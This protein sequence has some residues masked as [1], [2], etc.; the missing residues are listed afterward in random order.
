MV[1]ILCV[2]VLTGNLAKPGAGFFFLNWDLPLRHIDDDYLAAP[3]LASKKVAQVSHMDLAENLEDTE[4]SKALFTWNINIAASNPEQTRLKNGLLREDLFTVALDLFSTDTTDYADFILPAASFL[5]FDDL[6]AGYFHLTLSAQVK[7][8]EPIGQALPNQEIFR[9]LAR[10]MGYLE[11]ELYENDEVILD[12]IM[13][14]ADLGETFNS[15]AIKGT[16]PVPK[17]P[18]IQFEDLNFST[19]SGKIELTSN[20]AEADGQPRIPMPEAGYRPKNSYLR[21]LSPASSW[22]L[23]SSF[24]NVSKIQDHA[25]N[26]TILM[27]PEDATERSLAVGDSVLV[28]N[29]TGQLHFIVQT[30]N[31]I[32]RSVVVVPKWR[33]P[34]N[35]LYSANVNVLN[36]GNK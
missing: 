35:E 21:L 11:S 24:G 16:I 3:H 22:S 25:S 28:S 2:H 17:E 15:L 19:P 36:S 10:A 14:K 13:T 12:K 26:A 27:H 29:A 20:T 6:V 34:K 9:R 32:P 23:N 8:T 1:G 31:T 7:V 30:G 4:K 18:R 5:E 33:W